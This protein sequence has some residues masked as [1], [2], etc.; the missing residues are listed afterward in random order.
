M[1]EEE[2]E[3]YVAPVK[4]Y[5]HDAFHKKNVV[6][7]ILESF[8]KEYTRLGSCKGYTPFLD[9]LMDKSYTFTDAYAN[10]SHSIEGIPAIIAGIPALS[11]EP[12]TVS[13]YGTNKITSLPNILKTEGYSSAFYHGATNGSMSFDVFCSAAG[14]DKY[15][16]RTEYNNEA[17]YDGSWGITD[18]PF[19]QYFAAGIS[20]MQQPFFAT[21][22]T[23]TSH[24]PF[25]VPEPYRA[26]VPKGKI[27]LESTIAYTDM[28]L[29]DFF[30]T[31]ATKPWFNNTLFV[32]SADHGALRHEDDYYSR[33]MGAYAIPII[34]Y[35]PGD[36]LLKGQDAATMQQI[37]ILPSVLDYLGYSKPFFALGN[38]MFSDNQPFAVNVLNDKNQLL[39]NG[40]LLQAI[41]MTPSALYAFPPDTTCSHDVLHMEKDITNEHLGL[42]KAFM[43]VYNHTII[44]NKMWVKP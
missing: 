12:F 31:A 21:V 41:D 13:V 11:T 25:I 39:L 26:R 16:G 23:L 43:Q 27:P 9:S 17:D 35:A 5:P 1:S 15:Y 33:N 37:N 19:L 29:R 20:K 32:I 40:Y 42:L 36:T 24:D 34:F 6:V 2:A 30:K 18:Q 44:N 7:I 22:F 10:A 3:K 14:Y 38:S 4:R 8:S 28:A